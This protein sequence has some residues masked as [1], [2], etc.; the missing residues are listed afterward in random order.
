MYAIRSYYGEYGVVRMPETAA[1]VQTR[2]RIE[3]DEATVELDLCG[4]ALS[5]RGYRKRPTEAPLKESV[6]AAVLFL[7]GWRRSFPL[8]DPFCGSGTIP[9]ESYN[10]V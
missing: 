8:Y 2:V 3:R 6:A 5:R 4:E 9:I 10:F 1:T 7:S